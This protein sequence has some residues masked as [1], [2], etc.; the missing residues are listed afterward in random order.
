MNDNRF[1]F[2]ANINVDVSSETIDKVV[3]SIGN[4]ISSMSDTLLGM[5]VGKWLLE[6]QYAYKTY[7]RDMEYKFVKA[8][9]HKIVVPDLEIGVPVFQNLIYSASK[10][11]LRKMYMNLLAN[12][13]YVDTK[14]IIHPCL[15]DII[16]QLSRQDA[17]IF[18]TLY[19]SMSPYHSGK[20][21]IVN[22]TYLEQ[23]NYA[24][25]FFNIA[26]INVDEY[27]SILN[28]QTAIDNFVRLGLFKLGIP[29]VNCLPKKMYD[30]FE[31]DCNIISEI[32][33]D[34]PVDTVSLTPNTLQITTLGGMLYEVCIKDFEDCF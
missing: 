33:S 2:K 15:A 26:K 30:T 1:E 31:T 9:P 16:K 19:E 32:K 14:E 4:T 22:V 24:R 12:A 6:K 10:E 18:K 7:K 17:V 27:I 13:S 29:N 11:E 3:T 20:L 8:D 25:T 23:K 5:T 34:L 21:P 28:V